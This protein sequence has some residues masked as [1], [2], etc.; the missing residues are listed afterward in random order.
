M[1][2]IDKHIDKEGRLLVISETTNGNLVGEVFNN[3]KRIVGK[4]DMRAKFTVGA[5]EATRY[6]V[7][8]YFGMIP[9]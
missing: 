3:G 8:E 5:K 4:H 1:R 6:R 9:N 2:T 7:M